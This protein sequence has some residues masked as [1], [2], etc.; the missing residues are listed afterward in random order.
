ME[1]SA[2]TTRCTGTTIE[3]GVVAQAVPTARA[4][5]GAYEASGIDARD[6]CVAEVHVPTSPQELFDIE[7]L[8]FCE[9]GEAI[10]LLEDGDLALGGIRN[11]LR[12]RMMAEAWSAEPE[13]CER[14]DAA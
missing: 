12:A 11:R 2:R 14:R 1:P 4:A 8:L 6:V 13:A 3:K 9:R 5:R 7:D 10:R